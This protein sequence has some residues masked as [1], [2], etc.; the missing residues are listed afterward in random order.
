[1]RSIDNYESLISQGAP[2]FQTVL[3]NAYFTKDQAEEVAN[4]LN[5][6]TSMA[7]GWLMVEA[8]NGNDEFESAF[9]QVMNDHGSRDERQSYCQRRIEM[10]LETL[11]LNSREL[12]EMRKNEKLLMTALEYQRGMLNN[13]WS[14]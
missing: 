11:A 10:A 2:Y 5:V 13:E 8:S 7:M 3:S 9:E 12:A 4:Y 6:E 14:D 1:M